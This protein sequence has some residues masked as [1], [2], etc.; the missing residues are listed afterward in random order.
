ML[1]IRLILRPHTRLHWPSCW[2]RRHRRKPCPCRRLTILFIYTLGFRQVII[3]SAPHRRFFVPPYHLPILFN[4]LPPSKTLGR[5]RPHTRPT[6]RLAIR[7]R[8]KNILLF[9]FNQYL[10][11]RILLNHL[12]LAIAKT[13]P[14]LLPLL[15]L[16][17]QLP[18]KPSQSCYLFWASQKRSASAAALPLT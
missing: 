13:P 16:L 1:K 12:I 11:K 3:P 18:P 4:L 7:R 2:L 15:I 14:Y 5:S 8:M 10:R 6:L 17:F 9:I